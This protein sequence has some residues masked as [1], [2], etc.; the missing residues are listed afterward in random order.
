M[1]YISIEQDADLVK[2]ILLAKAKIVFYC[3]KYNSGSMHPGEHTLSTLE[4]AH[5]SPFVRVIIMSAVPVRPKAIILLPKVLPWLY[6]PHEFFLLAF[7]AVRKDTIKGGLGADTLG[8]I[9]EHV[10]CA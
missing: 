8:S 3:L 2:A 1:T 5:G 7:P 10:L 9:P 4:P 6:H